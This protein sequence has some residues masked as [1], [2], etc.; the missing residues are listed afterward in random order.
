MTV[1]WAL[2]SGRGGSHLGVRR[3]PAEGPLAGREVGSPCATLP[4]CKVWKGLFIL[5]TNCNSIN[6]PEGKVCVCARA[7]VCVYVCTCLCVCA[8]VRSG[9]KVS[10]EYRW[11]GLETNLIS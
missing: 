11:E 10:T 2:K 9:I 3:G 5:G 1:V 4:L 7:R 8:R 6:A